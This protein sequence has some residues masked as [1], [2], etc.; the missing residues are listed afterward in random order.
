MNKIPNFS[1][2][3]TSLLSWSLAP[4]HSNPDVAEYNSGLASTESGLNLTLQKSDYN[5]SYASL[6]KYLAPTCEEFILECSLK[7][8]HSINGSTCCNDYFN[9]QPVFNQYGKIRMVNSID[10]FE[11][12]WN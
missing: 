6:M 3:Q 11:I 10:C 4:S 8:G 12:I 2:K 7:E 5:N 1:T 9:L